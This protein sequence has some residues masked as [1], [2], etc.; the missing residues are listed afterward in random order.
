MYIGTA[1][2]QNGIKLRNYFKQP[3]NANVAE[4]V[5]KGL[6]AN[7][8]Y[9]P[10]KYFYDARGS[11]LF[12]QICRLPE[13]YL[14]RMEMELLKRFAGT[15]TRNF[16]HGDLVELGSGAN[17]KIRM[18]LDAMSPSDRATVHYVPVDVSESA[19]V[20]SANELAHLYRELKIVPL[21]ADFTRDLDRIPR[22]GPRLIFL[23]G[24]TMGNFDEDDTREFLQT[25]AG[26]LEPG[27]RFF[28]GL[29]MV[30]PVEILEAAY[31]DSQDVTAQFNKNIL[32]VLN[33]RLGGN[34]DPNDFDHLAFFNES[35]ERIEMHLRAKRPLTAEF[36]IMDF[37]VSLEEGE[38]IR[39]EICRKFRPESIEATARE[40]G[41]R[42]AE[43]Y[44]DAYAWFSIAEIV[45]D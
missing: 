34:F 2:Q 26:N 13:Y 21:V 30:K 24:S 41:L 17:W 39:T 22:H 18:L 40:S 14:T 35:G 28:V 4:D 23:F 43:W 3:G 6:T 20:A 31:N 36:E 12:E 44:T 45:P 29:D 10:S 19:V 38:T 8:K 25:L 42:V 15:L 33:K 27:D 7:E 11:Q 37:A 5:V 32:L 9:I 1:A 16:R